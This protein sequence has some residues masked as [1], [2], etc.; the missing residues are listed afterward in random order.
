MELFKSIQE[1]KKPFE[2]N[3]L[4][5]QP[6]SLL[7]DS[8]QIMCAVFTLKMLCIDF[9]WWF[10]LREL[11]NLRPSQPLP[12]TVKNTLSS[13]DAS[14]N[15]QVTSI[16]D[17]WNEW[18]SVSILTCLSG[19]IQQNKPTALNYIPLQCLQVHHGNRWQLSLLRR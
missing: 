18:T 17:L 16:E 2:R 8:G 3:V 14:Y 10:A 9:C 1:Y 5:I 19:V 12:N 4:S 11:W 6:N 7:T 13:K 15:T